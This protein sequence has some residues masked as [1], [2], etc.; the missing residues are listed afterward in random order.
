MFSLPPLICKLCLLCGDHVLKASPNQSVLGNPQGS[1]PSAYFLTAAGLKLA[2]IVGMFGVGDT[3]LPVDFMAAEA[4]F[5][6][7]AG[8]DL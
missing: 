1:L 2:L 3:Y 8:I 6:S 7:L 5:H 4:A